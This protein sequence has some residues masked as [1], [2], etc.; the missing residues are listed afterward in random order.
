MDRID[1]RLKNSHMHF[2]VCQRLQHVSFFPSSKSRDLRRVVTVLSLPQGYIA[3]RILSRRACYI[4]KMDHRAIPAL[5]QLERYI[6]ERK[7]I[8]ENP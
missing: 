4:L 5:D 6:Y 8:L 7:V 3:T 1:C 2:R